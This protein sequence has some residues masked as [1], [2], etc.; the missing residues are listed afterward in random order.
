LA[1]LALAATLTACGSDD[2]GSADDQDPA[3]PSS[4][5]TAESSPSATATDE[6]SL[7]DDGAQVDVAKFVSRLQAGIDSTDYAHIDFTMGGAGGE[8]KGTGDVDYTAKP[9]NMSMSMEIGPET[10]RML[11]VDAMMYIQSSQADGKYLEYDLADPNNP[12][13]AGLAEQLDPAGSIEAFTKAV[14]SVTSSGE[15]D[16]DGRTLSRYVL[17]IDTTQL[18][19]QSGAA[20]LPAQMQIVIWLDDQDRMAQTSM[21]TGAIQYDATLSGFDEPVE[22]EAPPK[23]QIVRPPAA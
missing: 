14:T 18:A 23:A 3:A 2:S 12:L 4:S 9:P 17:T 19:D 15:E 5:A 20:G 7:I 6:P 22:L 16:V 8:M 13:G 21:A 11:L 10:V 1:A